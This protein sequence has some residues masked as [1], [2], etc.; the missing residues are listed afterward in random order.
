MDFYNDPFSFERTNLKSSPNLN[1]NIGGKQISN[2]EELN[3]QVKN[4][5]SIIRKYNNPVEVDK[6]IKYN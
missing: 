3:A 1:I 4:L 6:A 5:Q 2:I